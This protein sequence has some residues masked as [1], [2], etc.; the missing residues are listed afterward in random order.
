[1]YCP[2]CGQQ[3]I[4]EEMRFCSRCGLPMSG[5]AGWLEVNGLPAGREQETQVALRS[6]RRKGIR[7]GA[8]VMFFSGVLLPLFLLLSIGVDEPTPLFVPIITFIAGLTIMLYSRL[9]IEDFPRINSQQ[10][11]RAGL[12]VVPEGRALPP[13][14][15]TQ[16][17]DAGN[18]PSRQV[19]TN[20]LAQPPS[21][22]EH[23]TKLL[24]QE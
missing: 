11:Q 13:G 18:L 20:E 1:M 16:I 19:R 9:F 8:K 17:Y 6:P 10:T 15:T 5:L 24:D 3:Q 12:G 14:S 23:T 21:V 7:R 2:R 4:S 22:A